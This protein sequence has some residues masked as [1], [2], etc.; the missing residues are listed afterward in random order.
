MVSSVESARDCL[1]GGAPEEAL[2]RARAAASEARASGDFRGAAEAA[3]VVCF[4]HIALGHAVEA[5]Q[6]VQSEL[7]SCRAAGN[8]ASEAS[9]L[10]VQSCAKLALGD[11]KE[12]LRAAQEGTALLDK[13]GASQDNQKL[14]AQLLLA[15]GNAHLAGDLSI[16]GASSAAAT[17]AASGQALVLSRRSGDVAG[18]GEALHLVCLVYLL[19]G[20]EAV[21]KSMR[22]VALEEQ[23]L[24]TLQS[25][26]EAAV[27]LRKLG[28]KEGEAAALLFGVAAARLEEGNCL[29]ALG[30]VRRAY[31]IFRDLGHRR[32]RQASLER[33]SQCHMA[34]GHPNTLAVLDAVEEEVAKL[35]EEGDVA[36]QIAA[37]RVLADSYIAA[38]MYGEALS[39]ARRSLELVKQTA[40]TESEVRV[41][42]LVSQVEELLGRED[43]ALKSAQQ[44]L[45]V[46]NT[47]QAESRRLA[48]E[49]RRV[50]SRLQSRSGRPEQAPNRREALAA[51]QELGQ[52]AQRRDA[53][54]FKAVMARLE[55]L[56]GYT[57]QDVKAAVACEDDPDREGL[58]R[59][60]R[61]SGQGQETGKSS[62][63]VMTG[64][65][66]ALLYLQFRVG[67]LGYGPRFRR[68]HAYAVQGAE[69]HAAAYLRL[70]SSQEEWGKRLFIQPPLL[71][72]MQHSLNALHM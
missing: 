3:G 22:S 48:A 67:G 26:N 40:A 33:L 14:R 49:A 68:C 35:R 34:S 7:S 56:S 6:V 25:S 53:D 62:S 13:L 2:Q 36:G 47:V 59:F 5:E 70:L 27:L 38:R 39:A 11:A 44:A 23:P 1:A 12:A 69:D 37:F 10:W 32:G 61:Q 28:N 57:E 55:D 41:L 21:E 19:N 45:T 43:A 8:K 15:R 71:D 50:V 72:S 65:S 54:G 51:L 64:L 42:L 63:T 29:E 16:Q 58:V 31:E 17:L 9:L 46:A 20:R 52:M 24:A 30:A 60:L 66:H 4:A 18:Q